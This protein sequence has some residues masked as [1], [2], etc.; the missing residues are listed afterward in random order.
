MMATTFYSIPLDHHLGYIR[1]G[2]GLTLARGTHVVLIPLI[3]D[4]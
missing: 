1:L 4:T 3:F 2:L